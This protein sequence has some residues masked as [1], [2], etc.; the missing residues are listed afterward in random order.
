VEL[1][2]LLR[3]LMSLQQRLQLKIETEEAKK[4]TEKK[5]EVTERGKQK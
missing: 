3:E 1:Q 2:K 4:K 5:D